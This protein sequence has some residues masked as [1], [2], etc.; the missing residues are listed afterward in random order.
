[1]KKLILLSLLLLSLAAC[2]PLRLALDPNQ[3]QRVVLLKMLE[4]G[5]QTEWPIR[6]LTAR[7]V[8]VQT[9]HD[10]KELW[11]RDWCA[12]ITDDWQPGDTVTAVLFQR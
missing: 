4:P 7:A 8:L 5:S 11:T 2:R 3:H 1:M 9:L 12:C 10:G 6:D